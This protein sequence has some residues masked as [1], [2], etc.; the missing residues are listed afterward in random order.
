MKHSFTIQSIE[1]WEAV[2]DV[3]LRQVRSGMVIALS[4]PLGAG[5]TTCVQSLLKQLHGQT[6]AKSPTF[7]LMRTYPVSYGSI[8]RMVHVDAYRF[9]R[10]EDVQILAL[11]EE[12]S[13]PGTIVV[14][15]W[16]ERMADWIHRHTE[17][18]I[19]ITITPKEDESRFVVL[20]F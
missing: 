12:L 3:L 11:E 14:I 13:E 5:K 16:P 17:R 6:E 19:Q 2:F 10:P 18:V 8:T 7:A 1:G 9:E 15:E 4:G 20:A